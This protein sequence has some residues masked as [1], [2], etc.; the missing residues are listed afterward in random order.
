MKN[1]LLFF[2]F[3][4]VSA[5]NVYAQSASPAPAIGIGSSAP[6]GVGSSA[7]DGTWVTDETVTTV[8]KLAARSASFVNWT[9]SNYQWSFV[10]KDQANPFE[11]V[12]KAV[13]N[14][15][16]AILSIFI[17]FAAFLMIVTRGKE[18][19]IKQFVVRF[20]FTVLLVTIIYS[21]TVFIYQLVDILQG[22]FLKYKGV[23]ISS[24]D[25]LNVNFDYKSFL[26]YKKSGLEFSESAFIAT[27]LT[28]L[29]AVTYFVMSAILI[30]RKI[31]LWFF[32]IIS[33]IF[34]LLFLFKGLRGVYKVWLGQFLKWLFYGP[35][36]VILLA[37]LVTIWKLYIP[38]DLQLNCDQTVDPKNNVFPTSINILLGGPCQVVS[39]D[40]NL[41]TPDSFIQYVV[42]LLMLW[43]VIIVPFILL[44]MLIEYVSNKSFAENEIWQVIKQKGKPF[45]ERYTPYIGGSKP[46]PSYSAGAAKQI[47]VFHSPA[48]SS[49][50]EDMIKTSVAQQG[51]SLKNESSQASLINESN[52]NTISQVS[53]NISQQMAGQ[54]Y[55]AGGKTETTHASAASSSISTPS[56]ANT[57][58]GGSVSHI[59]ASDQYGITSTPQI[60]AKEV[61]VDLLNLTNL[62]IPTIDD[63]TRY[64]TAQLSGD[65]STV[66]SLNQINESLRRI[67]GTSQIV[68]E[69]EKQA[70]SKIKEKLEREVVNKNPMAQSILSASI[71]M[72]VH[73]LP[74]VNQI[75]TVN[76][77]DYEMVKNTWKENYQSV[78]PPKDQTG[79]QMTKAEW[80]KKEKDEIDKAIQLIQSNDPKEVEKG[81]Q[82]L[83][84]ILPFL[85]L[86]GFSKEEIITYLKAKLTAAKEVLEE[87][88]SKEQSEDSMVEVNKDKKQEEKHLETALETPNE[89]KK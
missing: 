14:I 79:K 81:K 70:Y 31:I 82:M 7:S 35:L 25:L 52:V 36:F 80:L 87:V 27:W 64:E 50:G 68:T 67:A 34:P 20:V 11:D 29:T 23:I 6:V 76:I 21:L 42:A 53:E 62:S 8:G 4:L 71:P 5:T 2:I 73:S 74:D 33:P 49:I 13:R 26:G 78:E 88:E 45:F 17:L 59:G 65:T 32:L 15:I 47:P 41:N 63:I 43:M 54:S 51:I 19:S 1:I 3:F 39:L 72:G 24:A 48:R 22:F 46:P 61:Y 10:K 84:K 30:I 58:I 9:L 40:N 38:L 28:R 57:H 89:E 66:E 83:S 12:F 37:G 18:L 85:L 60:N 44:H 75:Q 55:Q 56:F 77:S 86:G 16:Y 69:Q